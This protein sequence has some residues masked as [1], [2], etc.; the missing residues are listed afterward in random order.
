M[1]NK[2]RRVAVYGSLRKGLQNHGFLKNAN[3]LGSFETTPI[4][5]MYSLGGYPGLIEDGSTSIKM[6]VY[7]V[8]DEELDRINRLEGYDPKSDDNDFYDR[9]RLKTPYGD[10]YTY[11][12][13][14]DISNRELVETGD[15]YEYLQL[16]KITK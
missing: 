10:A 5:D 12:Y 6:E 4:F 14:G 7:D 2:N 13:Q 16:V 11:I 1:S 9:I 3:Y 15:W 8:S